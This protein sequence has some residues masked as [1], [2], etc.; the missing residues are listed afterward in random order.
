M[1]NIIL[2]ASLFVFAGMFAI[3]AS[4]QQK[5]N[6]FPRK[7]GKG[8]ITN[9]A[10]CGSTEYEASLQKKFP[11]LKGK[12]NFEQWIAPKVAEA[13]AKRLQKDGL[14]TNAVVTIPVVFHVIHNGSP[15]GIAENVA[16]GQLISQITVLNQDFRKMFDTNGYNENP[17]GADMEINFCL[18]QRDPE[19]L[20]SNGITR[21]AL[22]NGNGWTTE[23][24]EVIKTQTQWNP[25]KYLNIWVFDIIQ[26]LAGYAQFPQQSGL[27]G[28]DGGSINDTANTDGVALS[29]EYVGSKEI[30]PQGE[31]S[32]DKN[33]GRTATHEIGH[34]FGLRHIWGDDNNCSATDYCADTPSALTYNQGCPENNFDSCPNNPGVDMIQNYMDYT[35]DA[36]QNIFTQNQKDRMQAVLAN[37]PRRHSLIT[38]DGCTPGIVYDNDGSLNINGFNSECGVTT[39]TPSITLTNSGNNTLTAIVFDYSLDTETIQSYNW[40]GTLTTGQSTVITLP[41]VSTTA[42]SHTFKANIITVNAGEDQAPSN[43]NRSLTFELTG[44]YATNSV[45]VTIKT[46]NF[47]D[48]TYWAIG[49]AEGDA[50]LGGNLDESG[51]PTQEYEDNHLYTIQV[52]VAQSGCYIF[53]ILDTAS[54]GMCCLDGDG[55]YKIETS[56]GILI[57]EGGTFTLTD[58]RYFSIDAVAGISDVSK[59]LNSIKL[60]PNPANSILNIAVSN[61]MDTPESYTVYNSLG[62]VMSNGNITSTLETLNIAKYA[63]GVYFVKLTKAGETKTLQFIKN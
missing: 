39:I 55:Y 12:E 19:G 16:D 43:D 27:S 25:E 18:A 6:A 49:D 23:Q 34:F 14:G 21:H 36:C 38:S 53:F 32:A 61:E 31:Y 59:S 45:T 10:P 3:T 40:T 52:P 24:V 5:P 57:A 42:G 62:Q 48:E 26:G 22:G 4:A 63:Q 30:F 60:Y 56:N 17:V 29:H 15:I 54:D 7:F 37:S 47:G 28:L 20:L 9:V 11:A 1:K 58:Q 51:T 46:D 2:R 8:I 13:K 35:N 41:E 33:L 44:T 50:L